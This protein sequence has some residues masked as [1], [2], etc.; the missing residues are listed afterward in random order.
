[1]IESNRDERFHT[2]PTEE[3][4]PDPLVL[5]FK[6]VVAARPE[7]I[8]GWA[9]RNR[10]RVIAVLLSPYRDRLMQRFVGYLS[11]IALPND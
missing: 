10:G 6:L 8:R 9:E 3:L 1:M 7:Y 11:R 4:V 2:L 5:D